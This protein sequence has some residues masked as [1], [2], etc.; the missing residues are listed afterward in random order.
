MAKEHT[1]GVLSKTPAPLLFLTAGFS[2]FKSGW[3]RENM[4]RK[5]SPVASLRSQAEPP[6]TE[7]Q[8]FG[9]PP[10]RGSPQWYQAWCGSS[11][12][13][14]ARRNQSCSSLVWLTTTSISKR[15]PRSC[16]PA[17]SASRSARLP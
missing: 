13:L 11:R 15:M 6:K 3:R 17:I 4:Y 5:Y 14:R 8:L 12:E 1:R 16:R 2:Q 10:S 9:G 7:D